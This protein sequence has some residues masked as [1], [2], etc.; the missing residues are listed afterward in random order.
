MQV[1]R[2]LNVPFFQQ[3][4]PLLI[5]SPALSDP[6][7]ATNN[8]RLACDS[9]TASANPRSGTG[10]GL[11]ALIARIEQCL[12]VL[13]RL[14]DGKYKYYLQQ[15]EWKRINK[16]KFS[17]T[18]NAQAQT[19]ESFLEKLE[20]L[21]SSKPKNQMELITETIEALTTL[22]KG[23]TDTQKSKKPKE[24]NRLLASLK[25]L[26][27][28]LENFRGEE[29]PRLHAEVRLA[30]LHLSQ[31][32]NNSIFKTEKRKLVLEAVLAMLHE[33]SY[34]SPREK[35]LKPQPPESTQKDPIQL[36]LFC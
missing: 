10:T 18:P 5:T 2:L 19:M 32:Q 4:E 26:E 36:N 34:I 27:S 14:P 29:N 31:L 24:F 15:E 21:L 17:G 8:P 22:E 3:R 23:L 13:E 25:I 12:A 30:R 16:L 11:D 6:L 7:L 28:S 35:P 1:H 9:F 20:A 33:I